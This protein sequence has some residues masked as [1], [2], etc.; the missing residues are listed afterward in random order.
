LLRRNPR[1]IAPSGRMTPI[2]QD[3]KKK[4]SPGEPA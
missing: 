1:C 2:V 3:A 4:I